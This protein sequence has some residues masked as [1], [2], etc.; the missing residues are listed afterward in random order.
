MSIAQAKGISWGCIFAI[1]STVA[2]TVGAIWVTG[3]GALL[4][5]IFSKGLATVALIEACGDGWGEI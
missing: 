5:F 3:G 2:I 4:Y 1:A